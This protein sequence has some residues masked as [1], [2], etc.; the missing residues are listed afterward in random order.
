MPLRGFTL[1]E[2]LLAITITGIVG[3]MAY[4]GLD[5]AVKANE[6]A[7][8][9]ADRIQ[10]INLAMTILA[11]DFRQAHT[12]PIRDENGDPETAFWG[13]G[14]S[15][16]AVV[17]TRNGWQNP[18]GT[19]RSKMQRVEYHHQEENLIRES[20][21]VLD[22][23]WNSKSYKSVLLRGVEE[24]SISFLQPLVEDNYPAGSEWVDSWNPELPELS[25]SFLPIAVELNMKLKDW[26]EIRRVYM[27]TPYWPIDQDFKRWKLNNPTS[28]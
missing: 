1:I 8:R 17:F 26:G 10:E 23:T 18:T 7:Q 21:N 5:T 20:W 28:S 9:Q 2:L 4:V 6:V 15:E 13:N 16:Q 27:V 19:N 25:N 11:R 22:R 12:R 14:R 24:F 3:T